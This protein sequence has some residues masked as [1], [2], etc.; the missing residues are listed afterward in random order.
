MQV[1]ESIR[2]DLVVQPGE[3]TQTITVSGEV[4]AIDTTDAIL[5]GAVSNND[6]NSLPLNSATSNACS[7]C[8]LGWFTSPRVAA[9]ALEHERQAHGRRSRA[10]RGHSSN[11][12]SFRRQLDQFQLRE[13]GSTSS[14]LPIDAI[15]EFATMQNPKAEYGFKDGSIVSVGVRSGTN[16]LHGTAYAFGR[17]AAALMALTTSHTGHA[18][19]AGTVRRDHRGPCYQG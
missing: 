3:Q 17:D 6:I 10:G 5:G 11:R 14:T 7:N 19:N 15:Q 16:S 2:V 8:V 18:G 13:R 12:P 1:S 4:P 9:R